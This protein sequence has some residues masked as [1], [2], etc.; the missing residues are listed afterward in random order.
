MRSA[1]LDSFRLLRAVQEPQYF[2]LASVAWACDESRISGYTSRPLCGLMLSINTVLLFK[3]G[4]DNMYYYGV[5]CLG[6]LV[7]EQ[8]LM[9][10]N[11]VKTTLR[12]AEGVMS[13][14]ET[15]NAYHRWLACS[16]QISQS[17]AK[18]IRGA[19]PGYTYNAYT[20]RQPRRCPWNLRS[21]G[22]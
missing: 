8:F 9:L 14:P 22:E 18:Y 11:K 10:K 2:G 12:M 17:Y 13:I 21:K 19:L 20:S 7:T 6:P 3:N 4:M 15:T 5:P 16:A 1:G